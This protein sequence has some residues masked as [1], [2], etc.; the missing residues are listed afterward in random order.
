MSSVAVLRA[1]ERAVERIDADD[2]RKVLAHLPPDVVDQGW[3]VGGERERVGD[4]EERRVVA[5]FEL[6]EP[7]RLA[8]LAEGQPAFETAAL[9]H[10]MAAIVPAERDVHQEIEDEE[11]LA[12]FRRPPED[13]ETASR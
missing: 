1:C 5:L 4:E 3:P 8:P 7:E 2:R 12:A 13:G 10:A 11:A 6:G 9:P